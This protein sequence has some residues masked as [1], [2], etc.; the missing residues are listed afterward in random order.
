MAIKTLSGYHCENIL[1]DVKNFK[2]ILS[3]EE[4]SS[5]N[6]WDLKMIQK[7]V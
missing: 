4:D 1:R 3:G 2:E 7:W 6:L 5:L